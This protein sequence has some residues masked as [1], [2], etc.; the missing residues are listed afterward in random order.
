MPSKADELDDRVGRGAQ[1]NSGKR[2]SEVSP[3]QARFRDR[4]RRRNA[5]SK[6]KRELEGKEGGGWLQ[7]MTGF[8]NQTH[9]GQTTAVNTASL[10]A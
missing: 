2:L 7:G 3:V 9:K 8:T 4:S 1:N 10:V 5:R 6:G